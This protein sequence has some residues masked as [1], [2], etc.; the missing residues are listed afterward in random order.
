MSLKSSETLQMDAM[1]DD[2]KPS[3]AAPTLEIPS[4]D[5]TTKSELFRRSTGSK[6]RRRP[7]RMSSSSSLHSLVSI[8]KPS[9]SDQRSAPNV[10]FRNEYNDI[11]VSKNSISVNMNPS[12]GETSSQFQYAMDGEVSLRAP[13]G[14]F[15]T[16]TSTI[17]FRASF[18]S[19]LEK[20]GVWRSQDLYK[21]SQNSSEQKFPC[22]R[23]GRSSVTSLYFRT[24]YGGKYFHHLKAQ[25]IQLS[26]ST[27]CKAQR[28]LSTELEY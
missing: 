5:P 22:D 27:C 12:F 13:G 6:K 16:Q 23:K 24:V 20:L 19:V 11:G 17:G 7:S 10:S 8:L 28:H 25:S 3:S 1:K 26:I 9:N 14:S 4:E 21:T 18:F 2:R 15:S